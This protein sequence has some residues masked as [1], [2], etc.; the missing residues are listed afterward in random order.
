MADDEAA[1]WK[2]AAEVAGVEGIEREWRTMHLGV[3]STGKV[4]A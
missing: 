1:K 2:L 4:E 3:C